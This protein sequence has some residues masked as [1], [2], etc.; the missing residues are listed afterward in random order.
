M[1]RVREEVLR[2]LESHGA[3]DVQPL[4]IPTLPTEFQSTLVELYVSSL[5]ILS[6]SSWLRSGKFGSYSL[7]PQMLA[8]LVCRISHAR[9]QL[10]FAACGVYLPVSRYNPQA[11]TPS[12]SETASFHKPSEAVRAE[13][14]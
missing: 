10:S 11:P 8:L 2:V 13:P 7:L 12:V 5:R 6:Y 1:V 3:E 9:V 4:D 14:Y